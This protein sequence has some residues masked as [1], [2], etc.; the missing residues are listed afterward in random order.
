MLG[1]VWCKSVLLGE[2]CCALMMMGLLWVDADL[3]PPL[4]FGRD[5]CA[6]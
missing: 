6:L 5:R 2:N 3:Q 1:L 4:R